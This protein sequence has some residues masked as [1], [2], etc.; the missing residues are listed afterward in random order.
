MKRLTSG[1][2]FFGLSDLGQSSVNLFA[3][4]GQLYDCMVSSRVMNIKRKN[5]IVN[6]DSSFRRENYS[7]ASVHGRL[8]LFHLPK[9]YQTSVTC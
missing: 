2:S 3:R 5:N 9:F 6:V 7:A 4:N 1:V 8:L